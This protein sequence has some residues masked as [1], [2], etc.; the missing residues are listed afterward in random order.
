MTFFASLRKEVLELAR[1]YRLLSMGIILVF[2]GLSSPLLA[3]LMPELFQLIPGGE[4]L[5]S[6]IPA[7]TVADAIGQYVKNMS[8]FGLLLALLMTMGAVAQEKERGT[9]VL[10]LVKPVSRATFLLAKFVA[11]AIAF[12]GCLVLAGLGGYYYTLLLFEA[13]PP[14]AW[15]AL[16][17]FLWLYMLVYVALTLLASTVVRSQAAAAGL[18]FGAMLIFSAL[19][20]IPRVGQYLPSQLVAWGTALFADPSARSWPALGIS[21][22]L[23]AA[24]LL[25]A[26]VVFER[27]EL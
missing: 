12:L 3:K 22:G 11:L 7:P 9:A 26:W 20:V 27:Q 23:I 1:T 21:L 16:N 17:L 5:A 24:C 4:A 19:G 6:V 10:I 15:L 18:G 2:F 14:S 25:A 8:Q 13:V